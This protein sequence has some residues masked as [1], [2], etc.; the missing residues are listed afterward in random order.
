MGQVQG[1]EWETL[2]LTFSLLFPPLLIFLPLFSFSSTTTTTSNTTTIQS[3]IV[4]TTTTS[5][6]ILLQLL[7]VSYQ[8]H[9]APLQV[10]QQT[11]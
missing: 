8:A 11:P 6:T 3:C 5:A 9:E 10:A 4:T 7:T 1:S 2:P